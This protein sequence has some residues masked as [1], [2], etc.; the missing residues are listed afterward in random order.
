MAAKKNQRVGC[1][2]LILIAVI[3]ALWLM[4]DKKEGDPNAVGIHTPVNDGPFPPMGPP[5]I[6][7]HGNQ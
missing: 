5:E 6:P 7:V 1:L 3:A 4:S 2:L